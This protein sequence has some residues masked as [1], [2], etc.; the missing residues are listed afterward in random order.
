[1]GFKWFRKYWRHWWALGS[2]NLWPCNKTVTFHWV[3]SYLPL[4]KGAILE[5]GNSELQLIDQNDYLLS[6]LLQ[7]GLFVTLGWAWSWKEK[8]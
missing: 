3:G 5:E 1:M 4:Q 7:V 6:N 8:W 2:N